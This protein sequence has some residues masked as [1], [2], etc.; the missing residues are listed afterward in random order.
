MR[1][2]DGLVCVLY[3]STRSIKARKFAG[4]PAVIAFMSRAL[5]AGFVRDLVAL[6]AER[7]AFR[8]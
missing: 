8:Q 4:L 6:S 3:A 1:N 2:G 5:R 7:T